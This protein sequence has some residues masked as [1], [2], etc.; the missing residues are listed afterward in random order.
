MCLVGREIV[1]KFHVFAGGKLSNNVKAF[2]ITFQKANVD[3]AKLY[4]KKGFKVRLEVTYKFTSD[5]RQSDWTMNQFAQWLQEGDIY[6]ILAHPAQGLT[7]KQS[8]ELSSWQPWDLSQLGA[9]LYQYLNEKIGWPENL[10]CPVFLQD[11][12]LYKKVLGPLGTPFL[13][14]E[15]TA[16]GRLTQDQRRTV[17]R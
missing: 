11:K 15:R 5:V 4:A 10:L 3:C 12:I 14:L 16:D 17:F 9:T 2:E 8:H 13:I 7:D 6:F 1:I